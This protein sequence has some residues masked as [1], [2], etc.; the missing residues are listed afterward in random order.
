MA[1]VQA[2]GW[3]FKG[4]REASNDSNIP[5]SLG[6]PAVTLGKNDRARTAGRT[7]WTNGWTSSG[8]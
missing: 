7:C 5:W 6:I 8:R 3:E 4:P 1:A 2:V